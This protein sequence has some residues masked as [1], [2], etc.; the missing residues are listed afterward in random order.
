MKH[1]LF[2]LLFASVTAAFAGDV[3]SVSVRK[4]EPAMREFIFAMPDYAQWRRLLDSVGG[5][6]YSQMAALGRSAKTDEKGNFSVSMEAMQKMRTRMALQRDVF[7]AERKE[8]LA[9]LEKM[10]LSYQIVLDSD[11][12]EAILMSKPEIPDI[13]QQVYD[14]IARRYVLLAPGKKLPEL[15][16]T[17][18]SASAQPTAT[19]KSFDLMDY[20]V[21]STNQPPRKQK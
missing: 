11:R 18:H 1:L 13:T 8:L 16:G 12:E 15:T 19:T 5:D 9:V 7:D 3:A 4:L 2:V 17:R 20:A 14:E 21:K 10:N 6:D